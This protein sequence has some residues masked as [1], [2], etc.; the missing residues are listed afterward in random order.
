MNTPLDES[1]HS[2]LLRHQLVST[3]KFDPKGVISI[4]GR[5][6]EEPFAHKDTHIFYKFDD[7]F[8][9]ETIDVGTLLSGTH[10]QFFD[11]PHA[12]CLS[13][14]STFF[15]GKRTVGKPK[16]GL[17][18]T[19]CSSCIK[20]MIRDRGY[21]YFRKNWEH[22]GKCEFHDIPLSCLTATDYKST[23][24]RLKGFYLAR[25]FQAIP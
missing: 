3:H 4:D 25:M 9:L 20:D 23:A 7:L 8:L 19:F 2:F 14:E 1:L 22:D 24:N 6:R 10:H 13:L 17:P 16:G 12:Y 15:K 18:I 21:A 11:V 5:W